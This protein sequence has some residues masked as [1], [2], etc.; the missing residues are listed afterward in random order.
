MSVVL[1]ACMHGGQKG[2]FALPGG[3]WEARCD[4]CDTCRRALVLTSIAYH[5]C[6]KRP[7]RGRACCCTATW[8]R[9]LAGPCRGC[10]HESSSIRNHPSKLHKVELDGGKRVPGRCGWRRQCQGSCLAAAAASCKLAA[11][12]PAHVLPCNAAACNAAH[13]WLRSKNMTAIRMRS[14]LGA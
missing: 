4:A 3:P 14:R 5:A 11:L 6:S 8:R 7:K 1:A 10:C 12:Q 9:A 13:Q 2:S